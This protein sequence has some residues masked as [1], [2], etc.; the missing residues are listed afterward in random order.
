PDHV[1]RRPDG[2]RRHVVLGLAAEG[3]VDD[4]SAVLDRLDHLAGDLD[5]RGDAVTADGAVDLDLRVRCDLLDDPGDEGAV[6]G[7]EV[8]V[9]VPRGQRHAVERVDVAVAR[10]VAKPAV[11]AQL[12]GDAG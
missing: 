2:D 12:G 8:E 11:G 5:L 7:I 6:P 1:Q 3:E 10:Y 9:T 4:L